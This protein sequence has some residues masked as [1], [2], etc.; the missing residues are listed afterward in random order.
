MESRS[1]VLDA[2]RIF[3]ELFNSQ[4][5]EE[6]DQVLRN[7]EAVFGADNWKPLGQNE[8]FFGVVK[9]QQAAPIAA[10]IEKITNS[11]DAILT[12]K[13]YEYGLD[14]KSEEA[15]QSMDAAI[16]RFY[17]DYKN[18][19]L[20]AARKKQALNIQILADGPKKKSS[21]TIYDD[22]EGQHPDDFEDTFLSLLR[23]NKNEIKF[24]QGKYNMGGS[25]AIIFCGK[26]RYQ[27]IA[28]KRFTNDGNFGFTLIREH[29]FSEEESK[30]RKETWY[31]Y[32]IYNN[33]IPSFP[34][35]KL[36]LNLHDRLFETGSIIKLYSY[37][38]PAGSRSVFSRDLNQ[39]INEYLFE[40][41]LPVLT[42]DRKERYPDDRNLERDLF[43][44]KRRLEQDDSKYIEDFFSETYHDDLFGDA[45]VTCY[46]FK[47]KIDD[48]TVKETKE[49]IQRE[50]FKNNMSVIF[51]LNGQVHGHYTSEFISRSLKMNLLKSHL[52]IHVDCTKMIYDFRK[53]LF[54]A[55]RDRLKDGDETRTL[56]SYLA[57]KLGASGG[58]LAEIV[59]HRKDSIAV[60]GGDTSEI[61][62]SFTKNLP[63]NSDLL[64]L[65]NQTFKL[66]LK[67]DK[68]KDKDKKKEKK[69]QNAKE[70]FDPQRY[71]TIFKLNAKNDGE[72]EVAKIPLG[73]EKTIRFETDVEN[74]YFDR[75]EEPGDLRVALLNYKA[76]EADGGSKAGNP[77]KIEEVFNVTTSSPKDGSIKIAMS[78]KNKVNIGDA[79]QMKVTLTNKGGFDFDEIFWVKISNPEKPKDEKFKDEEVN[80]DMLGM[81]EYVLVYKEI[82]EDFIT[83]IQ[84]E[85]ALSEEINW[86]TVIIPQVSGDNLEK[87]Y[88]NMDSRVLK[89][90]ISKTKNPTDEQLQLAE[91]KY[92][93]SVYFHTLFLYSITKNRK[94]MIKQQREND[95]EDYVEIETYLRDLFE[96]Y[97]SE[98]ILN[99]GGAEEMMQ[100]LGE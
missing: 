71:P 22:G 85:E 81:P 57:K 56:R 26:K 61:L 23:G 17:P 39:S 8:S 5:E 9:N 95:Q 99:F 16:E 29:P 18:W 78:P 62:K 70:P 24:V 66:D 93:S 33:R 10:L 19:D 87:I 73:G 51:S 12:K 3:Q 96:S 83:W 38:L 13:C 92:I 31:E 76:N 15:P 37:D 34:I 88:I 64:K 27:L 32:F 86:N 42:V 41:A 21:I 89:S 68:S 1:T 4:T 80:E 91:R 60:D 77:K 7:N 97:Y 69:K 40:P 59:R 82:K 94:Y 2:K 54:M 47:N 98:F 45:K 74:H 43:G 84:V 67:K 44:L 53:E 58:R 25:G 30:K 48:K 50:F 55:S 100:G 11:I 28:S 14:P 49:T 52:L 65:L 35:T 36:D 6:V 90:F 72:T 63:L 75:V 79:V 20:S 46:V